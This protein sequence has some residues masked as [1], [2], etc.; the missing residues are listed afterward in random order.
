MRR[1]AWEVT[2]YGDVILRE[3]QVP[4]T[5]PEIDRIAR[6]QGADHVVLVARGRDG[7]WHSVA[8]PRTSRRRNARRIA[9]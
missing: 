5:E 8:V 7:R 2:R 1:S 6:E 9:A 3:R 4:S